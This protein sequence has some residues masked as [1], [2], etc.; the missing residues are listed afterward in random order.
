MDDPGGRQRVARQRGSEPAPIAPAPVPTPDK[1]FLPDPRLPRYVHL[2]LP[3]TTGGGM[4]NST[5]DIFHRFQSGESA[6][7]ELFAA[8]RFN[9]CRKTVHCGAPPGPCTYTMLP[10]LPA[11]TRAR[12]CRVAMR[13][14]IAP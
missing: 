12:S 5:K 8:K 6:P 4:L 3:E 7:S 2:P 11:A 9:P 1:S 14:R 13:A 10:K